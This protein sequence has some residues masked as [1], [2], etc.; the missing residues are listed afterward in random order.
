MQLMVTSVMPLEKGRAT[1]CFE[2]GS[3]I[4]LYKG[5]IRKLGLT[6]GAVI[7]EEVYD[8]I[9]KEVLGTRATKRAM[10]LLERQDRTE[11][12]L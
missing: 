1:V 12:Q 10:H 9:L 4:T 6:E 5:E 3:E 8:T 2:D 7:S 11:R